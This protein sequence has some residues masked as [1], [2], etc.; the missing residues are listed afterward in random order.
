VDSEDLQ[1]ILEKRIKAV[2]NDRFNDNY[3]A[4]ESISKAIEAWV[5][6]EKLEDE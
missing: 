6:L 1:E 2:H 5:K 4:L 3:E